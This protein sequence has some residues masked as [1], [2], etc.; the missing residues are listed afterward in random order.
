MQAL[1]SANDKLKAVSNLEDALE[2]IKELYTAIEKDPAVP[3]AVKTA[4]NQA[5]KGLESSI[6][7]EQST[8]PEPKGAS[9]K[10]KGGIFYCG[11]ISVFLVLF[12]WNGPNFIS[13]R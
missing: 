8:S 11:I 13:I 1:T 10:P 4:Y 3:A 12:H 6:K 7:Q 5:M 2:V 9:V